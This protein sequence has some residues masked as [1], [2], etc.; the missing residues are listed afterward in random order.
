MHEYSYVPLPYTSFHGTEA[1]DYSNYPREAAA[2]TCL[3]IIFGRIASGVAWFLR[4]TAVLMLL[5]HQCRYY[6]CSVTT[7]AG[8]DVGRGSLK[9]PEIEC[10]TLGL[11]HGMNGIILS[12]CYSGDYPTRG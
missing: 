11:S 12:Y 2:S 1:L 9:Q 8:T 3:A 5:P 6:Q 7:S 4:S 10:L